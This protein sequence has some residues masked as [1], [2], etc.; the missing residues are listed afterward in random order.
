MGLNDLDNRGRILFLRRFTEEIVLN[1]VKDEKL[2]QIIKAEKIKRKYIEE[3]MPE[4]EIESRI[5]S[6]LIFQKHKIEEIKQ[7]TIDTSFQKS[8][9]TQ[10]YV[11][12]RGRKP[13]T[14]PLPSTFQKPTSPAPKKITSGI[15]STALPTTTPIISPTTPTTSPSAIIIDAPL[16]KIESFIRDK[17]VQNIESSGAGK[18]I[19]VKVR[20]K[21]NTTKLVLAEEDI[22]SIIDH[23]S[24]KSMIPPMNGVLNAAIDNMVI[25]AVI[26]EAG[27]RFIIEKK[28]PYALIE[29][30]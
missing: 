1:S 21:I 9:Q 10:K 29:N 14:I 6:S 19:L 17:E 8:E 23:F 5:G 7:K 12:P 13:S 30:R 26:S 16:K 22:R 25:S 2:K 24:K 11:S 20:N 27:S 28:S 18:N 4:K 3:P 15:T